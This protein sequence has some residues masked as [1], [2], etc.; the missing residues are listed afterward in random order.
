MTFVAGD[1][2]EGIV[3]KADV[4]CKVVELTAVTPGELFIAET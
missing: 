3:C 4:T 1:I 2:N